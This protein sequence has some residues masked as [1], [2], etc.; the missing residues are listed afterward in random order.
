MKV[1]DHEHNIGIEVYFT[2]EEGIGGK[3]KTFPQDFVVDED[4]IEPLHQE[5]GPFT[6]ALVRSTNWETN[7]LVRA[8][9]RNLTISRDDISF[10]GNKDK[11]A[12]TTQQ[13]S[14]KTPVERVLKLDIKN[15]EVLN[16]HTSRKFIK[17]GELYGNIF[18]IVLRNLQFGNEEERQAATQRV[19]KMTGKIRE[20]G[21]YP[22][23]FGIQRFGNLRPITHLTGRQV[24]LGNFREAVRTYVGQSSIY[25][26]ETLTQARECYYKDEDPESCFEIMPKV[27]N[28]ERS[29]LYH[30]IQKPG[31]FVGALYQLPRNLLMMLVHAFQAY[32]F[33]QILS[34]RIRQGYAI[35]E[36]L[37][38][39]IILPLAQRGL[40]SHHHYIRVKEENLSKINKNLKKNKGFV[41]GL[42]FGAQ[43]TFAEGIPGEMERKVIQKEDIDRERFV[44]PEI[45]QCSSMGLRREITSVVSGLYTQ[46]G[47]DWCRFIFRLNKGC[48]ATSLLREYMKSGSPFDF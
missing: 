14:F 41:G 13:F 19:T 11:R 8:F 1:S 2:E 16:A 42:I 25:E 21:G 27:C 15:V 18:D 33:N 31:D 34:E 17:I 39:D 20:V 47:K 28:F 32:L 10:S 22:N 6:W 44:V 35:N 40:P 38:G 45:P 24:I 12:V 26:D 4:F 29:M 23:F 37:E 46:M 43:S 30:L 7:K 48:Y 3:L 9:S 36:A 5:T